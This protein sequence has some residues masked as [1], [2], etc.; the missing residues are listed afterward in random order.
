[1]SGNRGY[2]NYLESIRACQ[3]NNRSCPPTPPGAVPG[4]TGQ[5]GPPGRQGPPGPPGPPGPQGSRGPLGYTGAEGQI[6]P[7]G[8]DGSIGSSGGIV[9]FMNIDEIVAI[10]NVNF[11]NIDSILYETC[12][13]TI[14]TTR[15]TND[16]QGTS[17]PEIPLNGDYYT[18]YEIQFA[19][20]SNFL[21]STVIPPGKWDMHIW[22]RCAYQDIIKLQWT[23]YSLDANG[24]FSPNPFAVSELKP[25]ENASQTTSTEVIIRIKGIYKCTNKTC[26]IIIF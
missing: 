22:V 20:I 25:I 21:S 26:Y 3:A 2:Q 24:A 19:I 18:G 10:N 7:T 13:P 9:L 16:I 15:V 12:S 5:P 6:G 17:V 14:K 8:P 23:L 11:Y 1:M 4:P